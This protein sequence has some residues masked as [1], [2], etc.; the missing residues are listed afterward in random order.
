MI[1][2]KRL[3]GLLCAFLLF[4][5][6]VLPGC[7]ATFRLPDGGFVAYPAYRMPGKV[8]IAFDTRLEKFT[9]GK[10]FKYDIAGSMKDVLTTS[11][12]GVFESIEVLQNEKSGM[13]IATPEGFQGLLLFETDPANEIKLADSKD[14]PTIFEATIHAKLLNASS[15]PV[16]Q[17]D[18]T[19]NAIYTD[20][21]KALGSQL[22]YE[23]VTNEAVRAFTGG[24]PPR[25]AQD[26]DAGLA[27]AKDF[28]GRLDDAKG[29]CA[30]GAEDSLGNNG[31]FITPAASV[32]LHVLALER[33]GITPDKSRLLSLG[34]AGYV[35]I[36][37]QVYGD[38]L[39]FA[40]D[41]AITFSQGQRSVIPLI[42][43]A[44]RMAR[45][46]PQWPKTP[47]YLYILSAEIPLDNVD[48]NAPLTMRAVDGQTGAEI[49]EYVLNL[50]QQVAPAEEGQ[51][52]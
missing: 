34:A 19:V 5:A 18:L 36:L 7:G 8:A 37:Y 25:A 14:G 49:G 31:V 28:E 30:F 33:Y 11:V 23:L 48:V 4:V 2:T 29:L 22:Q 46:S 6:I 45:P 27:L 52:S 38:R 21:L 35:R 39:D 42:D 51:Q 20:A 32:A 16:W 10:P 43:N 1:H 9:L 13:V 24:V 41:I 40:Q 12:Q 26:L 47:A 50:Q 3:F 17:S 44:Q 15:Q